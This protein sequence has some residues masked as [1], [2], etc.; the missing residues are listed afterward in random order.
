MQY[1]F[2][3]LAIANSAALNLIHRSL[4]I[5]VSPPVGQIPNI[6]PASH[7]SAHSVLFSQRTC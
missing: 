4:G 5:G 7:I 3:I 1:G 6:G 2:Q